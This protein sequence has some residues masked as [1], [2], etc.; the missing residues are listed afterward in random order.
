MLNSLNALGV[1]FAKSHLLLDLNN[2]YL[3]SLYKYLLDPFYFGAHEQI[4]ALV[5]CMPLPLTSVTFQG[6][7]LKI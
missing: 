4:G 2:L 7:L 5:H 3:N 6:F 1:P